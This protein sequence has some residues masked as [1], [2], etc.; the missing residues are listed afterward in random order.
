MKI[1]KLNEE[2]YGADGK[3]LKTDDEI[4]TDTK[5][6]EQKKNYN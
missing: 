6:Q 1:E 2:I 4:E 3:V 5:A